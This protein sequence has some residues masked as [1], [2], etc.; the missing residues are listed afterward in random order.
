[1]DPKKWAK[2]KKME[3]RGSS[4]AGP[5]YWLGFVGAVVYFVQQANGF[6]E[7]LVAVLKAIVWPGYFVWEFFRHLG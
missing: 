4:P 1:M 7:V 6:G 2:Y 5:F 3:G